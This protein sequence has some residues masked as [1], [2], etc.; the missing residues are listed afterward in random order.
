M[1]YTLHTGHHSMVYDDTRNELYATAIK[2]LV[3]ENSVVLD[4]GAGLGLHG[5][6]AARAGAKKVYLVEPEAVIHVAA[7]LAKEN[8][9]AEKIECIQAKAEELQLPQ[10]VDVIISVFTGNF[11]LE[12][13]LLPSLFHAR[14]KHL[15][16]NGLLIPDQAK[17]FVQPI[18]SE[19]LFNKNIGRWSELS[20]GFNFSSLQTHAANYM[21]YDDY[22]DTDFTPL[23]LP[24]EILHMDFMTATST[25][26]KTETSIETASDGVCHG[27]LGWFDMRLG[28]N[29]LSTSPTAEKTHWRQV[30]LPIDPALPVEKGQQ[31][32]FSLQRPVFGEWS[33]AIETKGCRQKYSTFLSVPLQ[34]SELAKKSDSY[35][36]V[37]TEKGHLVRQ[38]LDQFDGNKTATQISQ[39]IFSNQGAQFHSEAEARRFIARLIERHG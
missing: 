11:L 20:Q 35:K 6:I 19:I 22:R 26:C 38:A 7:R 3:N 27:F 36:P 37:L 17:M 21:Y 18:S 8:G 30:Y 1:S 34:H 39:A 25:N 16:N 9:L 2:S 23:A 13:D 5:F 31:L 28:N 24:V 4:L 29:W 12:E 14:D 32:K 10:P 15:A 33:W